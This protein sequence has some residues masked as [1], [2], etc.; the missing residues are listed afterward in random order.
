[1]V[2]IATMGRGSMLDASKSNYSDSKPVARTDS[3][4]QGDVL[5]PELSRP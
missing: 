3:I 4:E 1:M 5:P 2:P